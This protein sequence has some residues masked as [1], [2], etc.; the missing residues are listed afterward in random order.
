MTERHGVWRSGC[1]A[2]AGAFGFSC[3]RGSEETRRDFYILSGEGARRAAHFALCDSSIMFLLVPPRRSRRALSP[4]TKQ[5]SLSVAGAPVRSRCRGG[6]RSNRRKGHSLYVLLLAFETRVNTFGTLVTL[7]TTNNDISRP[8]P[9]TLKAHL[10]NI[11]VK[12]DYGSPGA[13]GCAKLAHPD[14]EMQ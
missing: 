8:P 6:R 12:V 5:R 1:R 4:R 3:A 13:T 2:V 14:I 7:L 9:P 10:L 11:N